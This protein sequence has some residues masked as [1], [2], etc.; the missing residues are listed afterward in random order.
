VTSV[1]KQH[2]LG[3]VVG[4]F[5]AAALLLGSASDAGAWGAAMAVETAPVPP[6][7]EQPAVAA[8]GGLYCYTGPHPVDT[9]VAAGGP[10]DETQGAHSHTY[11]PFDLRLFA[12]K[13]GCYYFVGDPKD[14]GYQGQTY[15]YYGAHPVM[16]GYGGGWCFMIGGHAHWWR[17][18]SPYFVVAGPWWYWQGPYDAFFWSY[19]PYYATY[20][21]SYY[22]HYYGGGSWRRGAYGGGRGRG[23]WTAAPPIGRVAAP[24][25]RAM[26]GT[27][28][29]MTGGAATGMGAAPAPARPTWGAVPRND[30][31]TSSTNGWTN[32]A[33]ARTYQTVPRRADAPAFRSAPMN[34]G[35]RSAPVAPS[36]RSAPPPASTPSFRTTPMRS[37]SGFRS[38]PSGG[39]SS[40]GGGGGGTWRG[41]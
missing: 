11:P 41:R 23:S 33:P 27:P 39:G 15:S 2:F 35:F 26:T 29:P 28:A 31:W 18:W 36:F 32:P 24:P 17:P 16:D 25:A 9:R 38:A 3:G 14:F 12:F 7:V 6:A 13:D 30:G 10:W 37:D 34:P 20:Y 8:T 1:E 40:R 21:G 22:P 19:W 4:G 5:A